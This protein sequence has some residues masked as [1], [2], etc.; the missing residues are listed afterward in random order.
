VYYARLKDFMEAG[1]ERL[2]RDATRPEVDGMK[3]ENERLKQLVAEL[4]SPGTCSEKNG[5]SRTGVRVRYARVS[6][7][8]RVQEVSY[9]LTPTIKPYCTLGK[10]TLIELYGSG[11]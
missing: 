9:I 7:L 6:A 2:R 10:V 8:E 1:E 3:W 11:G 5:C 4:S